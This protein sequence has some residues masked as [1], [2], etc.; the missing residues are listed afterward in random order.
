M[1]SECGLGHSGPSRS[2]KGRHPN[3]VL[4][5]P[6]RASAVAGQPWPRCVGSVGS[7]VHCFGLVGSGGSLRGRVLL[8]P[9]GERATVLQRV[10]IS[11]RGQ[12]RSACRNAF[13]PAASLLLPMVRLHSRS[14]SIDTS[15]GVTT[16]LA[17]APGGGGYDHSVDGPRSVF[18]MAGVE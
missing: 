1:E 2:S 14:R 12:G 16:V 7:E 10:Y 3:Q 6:S 18:S 11:L 4:T 8:S 9:C 15:P 5:F 13:F 17:A